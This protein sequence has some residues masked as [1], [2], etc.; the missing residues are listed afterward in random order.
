[1]S[2]TIAGSCSA[3]PDCLLDLMT[4][5]ASLPPP[6][7]KLLDAPATTSSERAPQQEDIHQL[8]NDRW[9]RILTQ[10]GGIDGDF[11]QDKHGPCPLCG[12]EDRFRWDDKG[13]DGGGYC[14]QCGGKQKAGGAIS[15]FDLLM[16][17]RG[18]DFKEAASQVR[19]FL[20]GTIAASIKKTGKPPKDARTPMKP[21]VDV[22]PP[23]LGK[24]VAQWCYT[25]LNGDPLYYIQRFEDATKPDKRGK[26]RKTMVHRT[27]L[28]CK[29]HF[30]KR[31]DPFTS[32]WP[33]PRPML[34]QHE[35][36]KRPD[37]PVLIVEGETTYDAACLLFPGHVVISWSNGSKS[38]G[39]VTWQPLIG[40]D[41]VIWPDNDDDGKKCTTKLVGILRGIGAASLVVVTP[42]EGASVGWD[43]ADAE[44]WNESDAAAHLAEHTGAPVESEE[45]GNGGSD[46]GKTG[47][48]MP[49]SP[50]PAALQQ[51]NPTRGYIRPVRLEIHEIVRQLPGR[52][53]G[54]PRLN[55]RTRDVH[56]P[57][58]ILSADEAARLYLE[59]SNETE[60]WA[61]ETTFDAVHHLAQEAQ[62]DPV[63]EYLEGLERSGVEP[64]PL[65]EWQRL[66]HVLFNVT[67]PVAVAF[68]PRFFISA[69]AR[70]FNPGCIGRQWPVL[71]GEKEI[72]KS[73]LGRIL[74]SVP[75]L[76]D[77]FTDNP[78]DL[79]RDGLM[80]CHRSWGVELAELNGITRRA[81]K[82]HLKA[83]LSER[84]DTFRAPY[85]RAPAAHPRRFVFWGTSNGPPMN[86]ADPRFVCIPLPDRMLPFEAVADAKDALWA[87][88]LQ[89]YRAGVCWHTVTP[90]FRAMQTERNA[91]HTLTDAWAE[92]VTTYLET[93][94]Q[95][96]GELPVT[97]ADVFDHLR[98]DNH[99]R[100][101]AFSARITGLAAE[102]GW[103]HRRGRPAP[104]IDPR[105]G[106]W[107]PE[108]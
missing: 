2:A 100:S 48:S 89:Q 4:S 15:G 76:P 85:S 93:R 36:L 98:I 74:F 106:L 21:P 84:I 42:P 86:E 39:L 1:M 12:G 55:V 25:D 24:A 17:S 20:G 72:G 57:E 49:D 108:K 68:L 41:V 18:W 46:A 103:E 78:G 16:R 31:T 47:G 90:G 50:A 10:L 44:D 60:K 53:G 105:Q 14:N 9:F 27:W 104:G 107:P 54:T 23:P 52:I 101:P 6:L 13:G 83:F 45:G 5:K 61:K 82:E 3:E 95:R 67:D 35:L 40:R 33:S 69:V 102:I 19:E 70:T 94:R 37:A 22:E 59:L 64:L 71:I 8:A 34:G 66:D 79:Q 96:G 87:R 11:L 62:F 51:S 73:G 38:V 81:D 7:L 43:L 26:P 56:L 91:D 32:E 88:A 77:G 75:N 92:S 63:R 65:D 29:W 30:P 28:D 99:Q 58:H 97:V 80:K